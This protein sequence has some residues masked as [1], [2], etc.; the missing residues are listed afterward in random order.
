MISYLLLTN[1]HGFVDRNKRTFNDFIDTANNEEMQ[2]PL[3]LNLLLNIIDKNFNKEIQDVA[4]PGQWSTWCNVIETS[5]KVRRISLI[6][7]PSFVIYF[8]YFSARLYLSPIE[9]AISS[10]LPGIVNTPGQNG[11]SAFNRN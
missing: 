1:N 6:G 11:S 2:L 4:Q 9:F 8:H 5:L 3:L 10:P 7:S